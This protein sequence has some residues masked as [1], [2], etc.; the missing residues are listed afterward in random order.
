MSVLG[1]NSKDRKSTRDKANMSNPK[2]NRG[3]APLTAKCISADYVQISLGPSIP[4]IPLGVYHTGG[5]NAMLKFAAKGYNNNIAPLA[6]IMAR[7]RPG[8][9]PLSESMM[10]SLLTHICA[11]WPQWIN[12]LSRNWFTMLANNI[13]NSVSLHVPFHSIPKRVVVY[14]T[15]KQS[16]HE[17]RNNAIFVCY[18]MSYR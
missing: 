6:H 5:F 14:L 1:L 17:K 3:C 16:V 7:R 13:Y 2:V 8:D 15:R 10:V 11:T 12:A 9:K 4:Y 18:T